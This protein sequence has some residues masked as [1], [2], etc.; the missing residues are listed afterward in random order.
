MPRLAQM[1]DIK[2]FGPDIIIK[3]NK[4]SSDIVFHPGIFLVLE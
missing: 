3:K 1:V 4:K 2:I